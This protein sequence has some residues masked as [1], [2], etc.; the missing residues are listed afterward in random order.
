MT[1]LKI[2][3]RFWVLWFWLKREAHYL[4]HKHTL[5][6]RRGAEYWL[7]FCEWR[8]TDIGTAHYCEP[9][10]RVPLRVEQLHAIVSIAHGNLR[11]ARVFAGVGDM[12]CVCGGVDCC[13]DE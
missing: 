1:Y 2:K 7:E 13:H 5:T 3:F 4:T 9:G 11:L 8:L 10:I 12:H 6:Q